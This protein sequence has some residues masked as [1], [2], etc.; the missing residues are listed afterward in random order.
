MKV[1]RIVVVLVM[2]GAMLPLAMAQGKS[3]EQVREELIQ[4]RHDGLLAANKRQYPPDE[5]AIARNK[6]SHAA[7]FHAGEQS[8]NVD[9]H[10]QLAQR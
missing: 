9:Q 3:R 1:A 6:R 2:T 8:P 4:A 5:S 7:A 10:D